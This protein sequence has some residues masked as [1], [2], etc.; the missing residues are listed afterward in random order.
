LTMCF[1]TAS[2]VPGSSFEHKKQDPA[3]RSI[4]ES[5]R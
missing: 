5:R 2:A 3:V 4:L 1:H